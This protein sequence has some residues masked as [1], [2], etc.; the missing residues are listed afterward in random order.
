[1]GLRFSADTVVLTTGTFLSGKI[2]IGRTQQQ[3][4]RAGDQVSTEL[5]TYLR[6]QGQFRFGRL[7][8]GTPPR[9]DRG[10]IDFTNLERQPSTPETP[11][12]DFWRESAQPEQ[13]DCH[14]TYTNEKTHD[15]I[16]AHL[17]ESAIFSGDISG[18]GPRY[19]PSVEDK[20]HRFAQQSRHQ[21]FIE[22]EGI[23][24]REVYPNGI[25]TSLPYSVQAAMLATIPGF[26]HAHITRPGYAIE[27]DYFD[28]R[29][30]KP[31]LESRFI[32]GLFFA[33]QINGTTG[34][35]EAGAQGLLAGINAAQQAM[36]KKPWFPSRAESYI[37]VLVDDLVK[38]GT[39]EPYRMFTSRAEHRLLLR[40]DNADSRLSD[41]AIKMGLLNEEQETL[42]Q[43]KKDK[44]AAYL[45]WINQTVLSPGSDA[46]QA[47]QNTAAVAIKQPTKLSSLVKR[48][49]VTASM[50][51]ALC[52]ET[53]C[54]LSALSQ[55]LIDLKYA[56]YIDRQ[57]EEVAKRKA[58]EACPIPCD[59]DYE[60]VKGFQTK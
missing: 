57:K 48:P 13:L 25:S 24:V 45:K 43:V 33:G 19:C 22:P 21:I 23:C 14:I 3:A 11:P 18:T 40:E 34:Y 42:W 20:V 51:A 50:V 47:L 39:T 9:I 26:E 36:G 60:R 10:T 30:L 32:Q 6:A 2:H 37:G 49:E 27:Y 44:M 59:F 8:T 31:Y 12:F 29:D 55:V 52:F 56:G 28:P 46:C 1:M 41:I 17:H 54:H 16:R 7:K 35:E 58:N 4:G 15:I 5:S 38:L 53:P